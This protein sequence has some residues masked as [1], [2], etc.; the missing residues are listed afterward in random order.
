MSFNQ[1]AQPS[2][3]ISLNRL[4][5][6]DFMPIDKSNARLVGERDMGT[7]EKERREIAVRSIF[8]L[9]VTSRPLIVLPLVAV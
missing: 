4:P 3:F 7:N 2:I 6:G 9:T 5:A 8:S 1:E